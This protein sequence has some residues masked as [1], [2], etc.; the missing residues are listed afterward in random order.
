M[1]VDRRGHFVL[2][3]KT[4]MDKNKPFTTISSILVTTIIVWPLPAH[5]SRLKI[6]LNS[7]SKVKNDFLQQEIKI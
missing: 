6:A 4:T 7:N 5:C 2:P 3:I 1:I